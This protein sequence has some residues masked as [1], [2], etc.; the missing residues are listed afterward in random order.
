MPDKVDRTCRSCGARLEADAGQCAL[1]GWIVGAE[2]H[3]VRSEGDT[4][5]QI[6][7]DTYFAP[8]ASKE[9]GP[10]CYKCGWENPE[11][12]SF[13]SSCGTRLQMVPRSGVKKAVLADESVGAENQDPT[14]SDQEEPAAGEE[15]RS[16]Q[17]VQ[18]GMLV[19]SSLLVVGALYSTLR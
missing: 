18:V 16:V 3:D 14:S 9:K 19:I 13:C 15:D 10:F 12:A 5:E 17:G 4:R 7:E 6:L 11:G 1:C 8:D 2:D